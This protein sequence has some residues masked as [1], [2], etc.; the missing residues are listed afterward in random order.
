MIDELI[1]KHMLQCPVL[2]SAYCDY[3]MCTECPFCNRNIALEYHRQNNLCPTCGGFQFVSSM[4]HCV[5]TTR[6]CNVCGGT[7]K[8]PK[9]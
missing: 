7:G 2:D 6:T 9:N 3:D 4:R 8:Y 5:S 1:K